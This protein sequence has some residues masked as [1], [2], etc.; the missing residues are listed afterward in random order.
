VDGGSEC[1][2]TARGHRS[3]AARGPPLPTPARA[4]HAAA[5]RTT[6]CDASAARWLN[7][8]GQPRLPGERRCTRRAHPVRVPAA[9][10]AALR[11]GRQTPANRGRAGGAA[12]AR[13]RSHGANAHAT[14]SRRRVLVRRTRRG[15]GVHFIVTRTAAAIVT[16]PTSARS[17]RGKTCPDPWLPNARSRRRGVHTTPCPPPWRALYTAQVCGARNSWRPRAHLRSLGTPA[18]MTHASRVAS[19]RGYCVPQRTTVSRQ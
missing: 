19:A 5:A 8:P 17:S 1:V 11:A 13:I 14:R 15:R 16:Y 18:Y 3:R 12:P 6:S 2:Q 9:V 10:E 4:E 7:R